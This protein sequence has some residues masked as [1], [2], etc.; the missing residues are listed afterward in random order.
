MRNMPAE[1]ERKFLL[2]EPPEGLDSNRSVEIEQGYLAISPEAEVRVRR[3]GEACTLTVK[4]G[5]GEEREEIEVD[6]SE[7]Q[8][9]AL[10]AGCRERLAKRRYLVPL[11]EETTAEVDVYAGSLEGLAVAEVEFPSREAARSFRAPDWFG[12]EVTGERRY[13]NQALATGGIP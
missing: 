5:S 4:R 2:E 6:L 9:E 1:I 11:A 13:A 10:W 12:R 3:A 7:E 8:F